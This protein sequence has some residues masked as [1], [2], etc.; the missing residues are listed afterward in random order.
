MNE[1]NPYEPE[2][3]EDLLLR[4]SF[5][6]L[7]PEERDFVLRHLESEAEYE[8][9]R[10]TLRA[11]LDEGGGHSHAEPRP[12]IRAKVLERF[13]GKRR[14]GVVIRIWENFSAMPG[15][16]KVALPLSVAAGLALLL[17]LGPLA[18]EQGGTARLADNYRPLRNT[19]EARQEVRGEAEINADEV[20][21]EEES[22]LVF[23]DIAQEDTPADIAAEMAEDM[24]PATSQEDDNAYWSRTDSDA[25]SATGNATD[26]TKSIGDVPAATQNLGGNYMSEA[27][28]I[29]S[30]SFAR[31]EKQQL[32]T[33]P[34]A[35][36]YQMAMGS[37]YTAW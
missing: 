13:R 17:W 37:L 9:I 16:G 19:K 34:K 5:V 2:D 33:A 14:S 22:D 26:A 7:Y 35:S 28:T 27:L 1:N 11:I 32:T 20:S 3:L 10:G 18:G 21:M 36:Q 12:E 30:E 4:K 15:W 8:S 31:V 24:S 29:D 25:N 23:S 6:E